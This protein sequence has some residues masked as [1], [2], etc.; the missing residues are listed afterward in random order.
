MVVQGSKEIPLQ[1]LTAGRVE[2]KICSWPILDDALGLTFCLKS[3]LPKSHLVLDS[4]LVIFNGP[5]DIEVTLDKSD[6][7][8]QLYTLEYNITDL[9][10]NCNFILLSTD[11]PRSFE[12]S[13]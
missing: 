12:N 11:E 13:I 2:T 9:Q 10:V 6:P 4:P 5:L 1:G 3:L 7:S 8:T